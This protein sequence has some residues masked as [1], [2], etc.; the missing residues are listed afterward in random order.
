MP[1]GDVVVGAALGGLVRV[2]IRD[3]SDLLRGSRCSVAAWWRCAAVGSRF[4]GAHDRSEPV[5]AVGIR[6]D[7]PALGCQR[8]RSRPPGDRS[9]S[10]DGGTDR[11]GT[12][13]VAA[14]SWNVG[15]EVSPRSPPPGG[16]SYGTGPASN[17]SPE[18]LSF[19][20]APRPDPRQESSRTRPQRQRSECAGRAET[21]PCRCHASS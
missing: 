19:T 16:G 11:V 6:E 21:S 12:G 20:G 9:W 5:R 2:L 17:P 15:L 14:V 3:P 13:C 10:G 7:R 4:R 8:W 18:T 1:A